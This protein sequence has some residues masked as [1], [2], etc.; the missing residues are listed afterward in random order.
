VSG[1]TDANS[2]E[3]PTC[4]VDL[5]PDI[6]KITANPG[7]GKLIPKSTPTL[8]QDR[9]PHGARRAGAASAQP[10]NGAFLPWA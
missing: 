1:A 3:L 2:T 4:T 5:D 7:A 10:A 9:D 8:H 6:V